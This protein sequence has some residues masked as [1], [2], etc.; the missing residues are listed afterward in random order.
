MHLRTTSILLPLYRVM[1]VSVRS[2][3]SIELFKTAVPLLIF[4]L[5]DLSI[6]ENRVLK[7]PAIILLL[8]ISPFRSANVVVFLNI[9]LGALMLS[10]Y[11]FITVISSC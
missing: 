5:D 3:C 9:Y 7:S 10:S 2:T 1:Y 6:I 8:P 11:I 4:Y